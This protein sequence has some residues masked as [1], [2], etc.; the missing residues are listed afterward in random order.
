M[1]S[2]QGPRSRAAGTGAL[3]DDTTPKAAGPPPP[4]SPEDRTAT[5]REVFAVREFRYL[6]S[7]YLLSL[8]GDQLAKVALSIVVFERTGS[9]L[10]SAVT[11]AVG[12]LPWLIGGP[13]LSVYA[14]RWPRRRVMVGCDLVRMALV[15]LLAVPGVPLVA[16]VAVLFV[17][18]LFTPPFE[19][20]RAATTPEVLE[21]DR[22]AVGLA[23][24]SISA[25]LAQVGGFV[26]G[27]ALVVALSSQ[28]ALLVNAATFAVSAALLQVGIRLRSPAAQDDRGSLWA[29]AMDGV[30][31]LFGLPRVRWLIAVLWV[32]SGLG[33]APEGLAAAFAAELDQGPAA[34]GFLLAA[35]PLGFIVGGIVIGRLLRPSQRHRLLAPLALLSVAALIPAAASPWLGGVLVLLFVSGFGFSFVIPL[36]VM[37][38]RAVDPSAR[39]RAFG[40]VATGLQAVQG[41]GIVAA[42]LVAEMLVPSVVVSLCGLLGTLAVAALLWRARASREVAVGHPGDAPTRQPGRIER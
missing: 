23:L 8:A 33:F 37:V 32:A 28:G 5:Y 39:A 1:V 21:G 22:Y 31:V 19:A 10:L 38:V 20:A 9:A 11:F 3:G 17:A 2:V 41:L 12:Y 13:L 29:D 34:V 26:A 40:I 15:G 35:S 16:L 25:Q 36:N 30:K 6:F 7:A 24:S 18:N 42:G 4:A 27:G 14:D